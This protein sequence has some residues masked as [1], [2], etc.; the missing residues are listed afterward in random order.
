MEEFGKYFKLKESSIGPPSQYLGGKIQ[1][2]LLENGIECWAFGSS[3]YV[4]EAV[5]NVK[6]YLSECNLSMTKRVKVPFEP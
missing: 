3:Q 5:K 1:N 6:S 2:V 4:Q